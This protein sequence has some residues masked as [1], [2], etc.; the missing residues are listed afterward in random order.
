MLGT[1]ELTEGQTRLV[2][3]T[4]WELDLFDTKKHSSEITL[5]DLTIVTYFS[6]NHLH[7]SK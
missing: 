2:E 5:E 1:V 4:W 6:A 3:K 7:E